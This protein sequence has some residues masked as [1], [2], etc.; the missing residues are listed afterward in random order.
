VA[1]VFFPAGPRVGPRL[2]RTAKLGS[3]F[4]DTELDELSKVSF[5]VRCTGPALADG[6]IDVRDLAPALSH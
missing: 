1:K 4:L 5:K 2:T 6:L 3:L